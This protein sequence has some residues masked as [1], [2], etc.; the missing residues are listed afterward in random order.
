MQE[1]ERLQRYGKPMYDVFQKEDFICRAMIF[2]TTNDYPMLFALSGQIKGKMGC[3]V[4]LDGTIWVYLDASKRIVYLRYRRF[5][6][7]NHKCH[8]KIYFRYYDSKPKNE[9]PPMRRK[10]G[11]HV[12]KMVKN[13]RVILGKKNLDEMKK[14]RSTPPIVDVTFKKQSIF[15]QYLPY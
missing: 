8:S 1:M 7:T 13:M 9:P 15:F 10:N 2:V 11:Q 3:L 4:Y 6:K 12:F 14:N 5:L